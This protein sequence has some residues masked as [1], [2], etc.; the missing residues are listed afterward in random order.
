MS[1]PTAVLYGYPG[2]VADEIVDELQSAVAAFPRFNSAHEGFAVIAEEVDELWRE[3]MA[4][5]GGTRVAINRDD[6]RK[7]AIQVAAMAMRFV[8]DLC[9]SPDGAGDRWRDE[10]A[11]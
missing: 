10:W 11:P 9:S 1:T 4:N 8:I 7:E 6:M 5:K 3:V 2:I